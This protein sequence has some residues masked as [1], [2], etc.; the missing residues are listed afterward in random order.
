M[1]SLGQTLGNSE[2]KTVSVI[3]HI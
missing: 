3:N 1:Y 2:I